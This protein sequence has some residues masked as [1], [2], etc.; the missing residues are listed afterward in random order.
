MIGRVLPSILYGA[1]AWG[2]DRHEPSRIQRQDR[3]QVVRAHKG[4]HI[5]IVEQTLLLAARGVL[6]VWRSTPIV[7]LFKDLGLLSAREALKE[8]K[9]RFVI[10]YRPSTSAIHLFDR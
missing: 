3:Q 5:N 10:C 9:L 4:W 8:V 2:A 1:E 6:P 7:T